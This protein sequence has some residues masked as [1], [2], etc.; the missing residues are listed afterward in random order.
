MNRVYVKEEWCLGC[1]LREYNCALANSGMN[2]MATALKGKPIYPRIHVEGN[3][4]SCNFY[5]IFSE[6]RRKKFGGVV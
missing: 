5:R 1:H 6:N 3:E 4:K 2:D